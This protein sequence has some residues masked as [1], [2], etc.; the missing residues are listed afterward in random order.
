MHVKSY[1]LNAANEE[2]ENKQKSNKR[3]GTWRSL[4]F[5]I[6]KLLHLD[7]RTFSNGLSSHLKKN[8]PKSKKKQKQKTK[9]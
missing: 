3:M 9:Q 4:T 7:T 5:T 1:L 8:K 6:R 2:K